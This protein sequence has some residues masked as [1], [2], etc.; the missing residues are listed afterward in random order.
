MAK[1]R[2][3]ETDPFTGMV[4]RYWMEDDGKIGIQRVNPAIHDIV[5]RNK[6]IQNEE[7]NRKWGDGKVFASVPLEVVEKELWEAIKNKDQDYLKKWLNNSDNRDF[8]RKLGNV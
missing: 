2:F 1:F 7:L 3:E 8:R 5:D 6:A 4:T